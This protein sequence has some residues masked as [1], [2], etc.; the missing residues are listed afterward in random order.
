MFAFSVKLK[1][2]ENDEIPVNLKRNIGLKIKY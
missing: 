1:V 2:T